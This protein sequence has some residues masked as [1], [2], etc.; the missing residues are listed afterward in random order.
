MKWLLLI[1]AVAPLVAAEFRGAVKSGATA[2]PGAIVTA[3]RGS[4]AQRTVTDLQG[5]FVFADLSGEPWKLTVTMQGFAPATADTAS[6]PALIELRM[7][8]IDEIRAQIKQAPAVKT[9]VSAPVETTKTAA[10][11]ETLQPELAQ[12]AVDSMLINGSSVN[13]AASQFSQSS[14]FGNS[15]SNGKS[16]YNGSLGVILDNSSFDAK[17]YSLTGQS[18]QRPGYSRLQGISSFGGPLTIAHVL[19]HGPLIGITYQWMRNGDSSTGSAFV[20]TLAQRNGEVSPGIVIPPSRISPQAA[21]LLRLYPLPNFSSDRY[22]F[23]TALKGATHDDSLQSR[24][25][26]R[27]SQKD[28]LSGS[29]NFQSTRI[30]IPS[31]FGFVDRSRTGGL[32]TGVSWLHNLRPRLYSVLSFQFS[33]LTANTDPFFTNRSNISGNAGV[34]G[35]DQEPVNWGPPSLSFASGIATLQDS[36]WARNRNQTTGVS[37]ETTWNRNRHNLTFGGDY[38]RQQWNGL[39][40]E[41]PRGSF[42]FTGAA[43]G[44]DF[45]D[46]LLGVPDTSAIAFGNADKYFR[47]IQ[48]DAYV[49]DDWRFKPNITLTLGLRWEYSS[50]IHELYGRLVNLDIAPGFTA[51]A[52][53][54]G[55]ALRPD[56]NN[57]A[58]RFGFALRPIPASSLV[59]RGGYGIY[60]DTSVYQPIATQLAQ[61]APLSKSLRVQNSAA[62]PL[63]LADGFGAGLAGSQNTFAVDPRFRIGY[64]QN[65]ALSAQRDLP[66][67]LVLLASYLGIKGTR[68]QQQSLPNT[69]PAGAL[70]PCPA[71]PTGFTYLASNGNSIRQAADLE[72]R[73]RLH[74]GLAVTAHYTWS[75]S[76]D[77][78]SLGGKNQGGP[79]IA[80]NWLD[81]RSERALSY[82][83]QRHLVAVTSQYSS[84]M[85]VAGGMLLSGWRGALLKE[86]TVTNKLTAGS[87][88]PQTPIYYFATVQGTGVTGSIRPDYTGA[89]LYNAPPGLA[90]NPNAFTAPAPG[91]WGNAG[92]NSITGP[93]QLTFNSSLARTFRKGD[94]VSLDFRLDATN[95]L[96]HPVYTGWNTLVASSQFGLPLAVNPMRSLQAVIRARF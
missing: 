39:Y 84:G 91:R 25:Q 22:N 89:P 28:Q 20:P 11:T 4:D 8:G 83:D 67:G 1:C 80:Q 17:P 65:W 96:N 42:A 27:A 58:P 41:N 71:C 18:T 94:H 79:L 33:R 19:R 40:Q 29:F 46:F 47:A 77:N 48:P 88:M 69:Y 13:G 52:P 6:P 62:T 87:G 75:K 56:R 76:I 30:D 53:V 44:N 38:R 32:T 10:P 59:L 61:Q 51:A 54:I 66:Q 36:Q 50:P 57:L 72:I 64:A 3:N 95:A 86:W 37:L 70:N 73:R 81:L 21:A 43:S 93:S 85:G 78:A 55:A 49:S 26:K 60:Y 16:L 74:S 12:K 63:S 14:A 7:L 90:L 23:Q 9:Q 82:F 15:R 92:R 68:A 2:I 24:W 45:Q 35:N 31:I 34:T 5:K